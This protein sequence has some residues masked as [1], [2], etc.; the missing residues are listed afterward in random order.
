M[1]CVM[2]NRTGFLYYALS[3]DAGHSW[4]QARPLRYAPDGP[5]LRQPLASCP[6]YKLR[7]GRFVQI[8]HNNSGDA[9]GGVSV[10]DS[11]KN[12]RPVFLAV[13]REIDHPDHPIMFTR[14]R[15]LADNGGATVGPKHHTQ[16]GTYP[17]LFEFEGKVYFWYPDRK[18]YL[19]GK[20][21]T[22]ELLDDPGLP[23]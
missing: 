23:K 1:I 20:I 15:L 21:L 3:D 19:L 2:R 14:A 12:R 17:S 8:F 10:S 22:P 9:N 7:D 16:I 13:G 6:L 18:H 4:D 11:R 5:M